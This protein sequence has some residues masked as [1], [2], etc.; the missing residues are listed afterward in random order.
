MN[1]ELEDSTFNAQKTEKLPQS[2]FNDPGRPLNKWEARLALH[3][4]MEKIDTDLVQEELN[5]ADM[6]G[7]LAEYGEKWF[8]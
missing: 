7:L 6:E 4:I 1:S 3:K 2:I 5:D 8:S